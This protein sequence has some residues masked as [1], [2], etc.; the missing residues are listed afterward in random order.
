MPDQGLQSGDRVVEIAAVARTTAI[1]SGAVASAATTWLVRGSWRSSLVALVLGTFI[2]FLVS[3][4][5]S[6]LYSSSGRTA[7]VRVGSSSLSATVPAGLL[8]G[9]SAALVVGIAVLWCFSAWGQLVL[10]LGTSLGCG[11]VIGIILAVLASL[12]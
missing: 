2:G 9:L 8:G 1:V 4:F 10:L 12:L 11:L 6:R 3:L 7:V 5:P